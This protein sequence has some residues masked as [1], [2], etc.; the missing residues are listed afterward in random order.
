[1]SLW[2]VKK[3][4]QS[5]RI[6]M[7]YD[8]L[9]PMRDIKL[10]FLSWKY[11]GS[12]SWNLT[13]FAFLLG[14]CQ[15]MATKCLFLWR[16]LQSKA[17]QSCAVMETLSSGSGGGGLSKLR[18]VGSVSFHANTGVGPW[19]LVSFGSL[20]SLFDVLT[21]KFLFTNG[22]QSQYQPAMLGPQTL[23]CR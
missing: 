15:A 9:W 20:P 18:A 7:S 6:F 19:L 11:I 3:K 22:F 10:H 16:P 1:M 2:M 4:F 17:I 21:F 13:T 8:I 23:S 12:Q 14:I 5:G